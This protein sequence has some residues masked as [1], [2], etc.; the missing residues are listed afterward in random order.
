MNLK[1]IKNNLETNIKQGVIMVI[2]ELKET[3][4]QQEKQNKKLLRDKNHLAN[5]NKDL[6]KDNRMLYNTL[7]ELL[8][9]EININEIQTIYKKVK[10]ILYNHKENQDTT[11]QL[12]QVKETTNNDYLFNIVL[13]LFEHKDY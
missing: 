1:S 3:I 10:T 8:N 13:S 2:G 6:I 11:N 9:N 4:S 5:K 12:R 7:T